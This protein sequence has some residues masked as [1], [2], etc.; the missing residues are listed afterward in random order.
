MAGLWT[1][2]DSISS[3]KRAGTLPLLYLTRMSPAQLLLGKLAAT[4]IPAV[5]GL[6]ALA[7]MM[8]IPLMAG[9]VTGTQIWMMGVTFL[10]ALLLSLSAG[11]LASAMTENENAAAGLTLGLV[12][13]PTI[14]GFLFGWFVLL[15]IVCSPPGDSK[16][17]GV[18]LLVFIGL[19]VVAGW[20]VIKTESL[21]VG[22]PLLAWSISLA[23]E[24]GAGSAGLFAALLITSM[25]TFFYAWHAQIH[26]TRG[27]R[28]ETGSASEKDVV[29][30]TVDVAGS[31]KAHG[32]LRQ[33]NVFRWWL[34]MFAPGRALLG[35][36]SFGAGMCIWALPLSFGWHWSPVTATI[37]LMFKVLLALAVARQGAWFFGEARRTGLLEVLL[38]TPISRT[39]L[40]RE[41]MRANWI[42]IRPAMGVI[43]VLHGFGVLIGY[44]DLG[45]AAGFMLALVE[46]LVLLLFIQCSLQ[47]GVRYGLAGR[48]PYAAAGWAALQVGLPPAILPMITAA[49]WPPQYVSEMLHPVLNLVITALYLGAILVVTWPGRIKGSGF[50]PK[51]N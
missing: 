51:Q 15:I 37:S 26:V 28:H 14:G 2:A 7:P 24:L 10:C 6:I 32:E 42:C 19:L 31:R 36:T 13:A 40:F 8:V 49:I 12:L 46:V 20:A 43:F 5:Y 34:V 27:F 23:G 17:D 3:E 39:E 45:M 44:I 16:R 4:S 18:M 29:R 48:K 25:F 11:L 47:L 33:Q 9:G 41:Q 38:T 22:T 30:D 1:T 21:M 50:L 35:W